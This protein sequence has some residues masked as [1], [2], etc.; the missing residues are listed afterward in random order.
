MSLM[1]ETTY[2]GGHVQKTLLLACDFAA[3][4]YRVADDDDAPIF[5]LHGSKVERSIT[6]KEIYGTNPTC[7]Y[8][9]LQMKVLKPLFRRQVVLQDEFAD[10]AARIRAIK[11]CLASSN[12][13]TYNFHQTTKEGWD[14][15][16]LQKRQDELWEHVLPASVERTTDIFASASDEITKAYSLTLDHLLKSYDGKS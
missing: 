11:A 2:H 15:E 16:E 9:S 8:D 4:L 14:A 13:P 7:K 1:K 3:R 10:Y 6:I 12:R 5:C